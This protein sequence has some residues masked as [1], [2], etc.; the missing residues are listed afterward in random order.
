MTSVIEMISL[1]CVGREAGG[2][3]KIGFIFRYVSRVGELSVTSVST[4][5]TVTI[6]L[7]VLVGLS[8]DCCSAVCSGWS[9]IR[10]GLLNGSNQW[11]IID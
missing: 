9:L 11:R 1:F 4:V 2:W 8:S 7:L 6:V 10:Y 3:C 5:T